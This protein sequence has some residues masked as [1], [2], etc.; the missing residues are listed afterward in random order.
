MA[1]WN[2]YMIFPA[3]CPLHCPCPASLP[4]GRPHC[5]LSTS[6]ASTYSKLRHKICS[7]LD[8][9]QCH[10]LYNYPNDFIKGFNSMMPL[11]LPRISRMSIQVLKKNLPFRRTTRDVLTPSVRL[12][13][14]KFLNSFPLHNSPKIIFDVSQVG[15]RFTTYPSQ[16]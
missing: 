4:E 5:A 9:C 15:R 6:W 3:L 7:T 2:P 1:Q 11:R 10:I 13:C 14:F 8:A 12:L 16:F